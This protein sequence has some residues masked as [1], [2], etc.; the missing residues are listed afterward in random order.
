MQVGR[1]VDVSRLIPLFLSSRENEA[2]D[3]K[4]VGKTQRQAFQDVEQDESLMGVG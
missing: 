4:G 1:L 3:R 2:R